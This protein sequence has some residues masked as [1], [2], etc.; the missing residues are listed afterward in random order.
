VASTLSRGGLAAALAAVEKG[1]AARHP[2]SARRHAGAASH[3]PGGNTRTVLHYSP[4]PLTWAHGEGSHLT[5]IDGL[6]YLDLLGEFSAGLYG[7][8]NPIIQAAMIKALEDGLVLG[9]PNVYEARLADA[10]CARFT[11]MD[12]VRFTN[13][14]TEAN[15]MALSMAR[16][17]APERTRVLVFDGAYHGGVFYFRKGYPSLNAPFDWL[18]AQFNDTE[19]TRTLLRAQGASI[20]AVIVEPMLGRGCIAG[21]AEFLRMLREECT[22]CGALLIFDEVMTSRLSPAGLQGLL[23][24]RPDM[25]TLG[26]YLGGGAS[27]GAFG[28]RR[29][30]LQRLDP[31][32]P[33]AFSHAGTFNNNVL[34]MAGGLAGLTEVFLPAEARR[35]NALGDR[36][37]GKLNEVGASRGLPFQASG[38][39]SLIGMHFCGGKI[40]NGADIAPE[41]AIE[42]LFHLEMIEHGYYFA[43]RGYISLSLPTTE[44]ECDGF[45][46]AVDHFLA[47]R[48]ALIPV[49]R[50]DSG[51]R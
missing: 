2:N 29:D 13:S 51:G 46:A 9:G 37:R 8:S 4:F 17:L 33:D 47:T 45:V 21:S 24:I 20:A 36:L 19:G 38:V 15:L 28:G 11:S 39:G 35:I 34:S 43:R 31:A 23:G 48:G 30:I 44:A 5:D 40:G 12:L 18:I 14:G 3:L 49:D 26:K 27:F 50:T 1:Y 41:G 16:A 6:G 42:S 7:H 25:T 10:I 22:A 32:R